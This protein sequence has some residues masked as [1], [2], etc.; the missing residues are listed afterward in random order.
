MTVEREP[1]SSSTAATSWTCV[2]RSGSS[3]ARPDRPVA[4]MSCRITRAKDASFMLIDRITSCSQSTSRLP[5]NA[6]SQIRS[7]GPSPT[8]W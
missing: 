3:V 1:A 5:M 2:S 6:W 7:I 4:R 8:T